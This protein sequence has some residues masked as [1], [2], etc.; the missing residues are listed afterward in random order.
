LK[1]KVYGSIGNA[2]SKFFDERIAQS[3]TL[4]GRCIVRH[5]GSKINE[6]IDG[7]YN[8]KGRSVIY[9]DS[10]TGDTMIRTSIGTIPIEQLFLECEFF[11]KNDVKEYGMNP[12]ITVIGFDSYEM[13]A[14][15]SRIEYVM[16]HKTEKRLFHI[17][18]QNDKN[19]TVTEDHSLIIDR[20]GFLEEVKPS[21]IKETD[22]I[23]TLDDHGDVEY[24][25]ILS[26]TDM[27][28][29][30]DYV[31]DISIAD[32][33]HMFFGNDILV[34]N[35]DSCDKNSVIETNVGQRRIEDLFLCGNLFW[36]EGDKEY[37]RNDSIKVLGYDQN[38]N[39][40]N[41]MPYNYVYRHKVSKKKYK[42][43][44]SS[45]KSVIV[46]EDHSVMVL[47][48]DNLIEKKPSELKK[49]DVVITV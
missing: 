30:H 48:D 18:T 26:A 15:P 46:T 44:T 11:E 42:I 8:Y 5:M 19:I 43:T 33:D 22:I 10:V 9:G 38:T 45:G 41:M 39:E 6:I 17:I 7:D 37:S 12:F 4:T 36:Q 16:R 13:K 49:N 3:T 25:N 23:I 34:H 35:T 40:A 1:N 27:G 21:D 24:T 14:V 47:D 32:G 2:A 31:Y 20:D 28:I 29:L